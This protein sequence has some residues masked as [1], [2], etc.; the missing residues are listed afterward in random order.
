MGGFFTVT[1]FNFN[2]LVLGLFFC[3]LND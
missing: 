3:F 2:K 1:P